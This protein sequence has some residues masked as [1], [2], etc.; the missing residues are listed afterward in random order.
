MIVGFG[1][2]RIYSPNATYQKVNFTYKVKSD[3][4]TISEGEIPGISLT[5]DKFKPDSNNIIK[6]NFTKQGTDAK[7]TD[8]SPIKV[9]RG[10]KFHMQIKMTHDDY[11]NKFYYGVNGQDYEKVSNMDM[12]I[13]KIENSSVLNGKTTV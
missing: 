7:V 10:Q 2:F 1:T 8:H 13:F 12:G 9:Q 6:F 3:S 11:S 4:S 5:F